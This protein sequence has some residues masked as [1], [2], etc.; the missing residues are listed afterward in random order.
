K[1]AL[2]APDEA[3]RQRDVARLTAYIAHM[4]L[5]QREWED[6]LVPRA[7]DLLE[8]DRPR[9]G[10]TDLRRFEWFSLNRLC[11]SDLMTLRGHTG[12]VLGV[13]FSPDGRRI[14]SASEDQMVKLWDA[15][16][17]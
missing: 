8:R 10:E 15:W 4:N 6:A 2:V 16:D 14:A 1:K 9:A 7:L 3:K 12:E 5:A 13:V 17:K 11:H